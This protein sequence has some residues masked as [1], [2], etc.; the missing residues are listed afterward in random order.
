MWYPQRDMRREDM[1]PVCGAG[2]AL[3]HSIRGDCTHCALLTM[4]VRLHGSSNSVDGGS[5]AA[6]S[7]AS[8]LDKARDAR[9]TRSAVVRQRCQRQLCSSVTFKH[10]LLVTYIGYVTPPPRRSSISACGEAWRRS[11]KS[12]RIARHCP[13]RRSRALSRGLSQR[14]RACL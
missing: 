7:V 4:R 10:T 14:T 1:P 6:Y 5:D 2:R 9:F 12:N 11:S 13:L 8:D 3:G